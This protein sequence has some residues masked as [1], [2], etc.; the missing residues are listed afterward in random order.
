MKKILFPGVFLALLLATSCSKDEFTEEDATNAQKEIISYQDSIDH[1]R[2]SLNHIG[3][4]IQ[5]SVSVIPVNGGTGFSGG[6]S[7]KS[8]NSVKSLSGA[9][10]SVSQHG[11]LLKDT[12]DETGI[13]V[14]NDL[15]VGTVNVNVIAA[16]YT[17][18]NFIAEIAPEDDPNVNTYYEVLRHAATMVPVFSLTEGTSN[19]SG[20]LSY[21]TDLTNTA[22]EIASDVTVIAMIDVD[23]STFQENYFNDLWDDDFGKYHAKIVQIAYTDITG[24][25]VSDA[26]GAYSIE[27][28]SAADGLPFKLEISDIAV[29]QQLLMST[30]NDQP[31][32]GVQVVR[33]IFSSDLTY[34]TASDIDNVPAAYVVFGEPT[35]TITQQPIENAY[36]YAVIGES[37]IASIIITD[38]G[39]GY[40][41]PPIITITGDGEGAEA[42]AFITEGKVT[43]V[44]IT[45]AGKGYTY[46]NVSADDK[47]GLD[48]DA[49]PVITYGITSIN[50]SDNGSGYQSR[51]DISIVS[52]EGSGAS[53][54]AIM[55]GYVSDITVTSAGNNYVCP[56]TVVLT[57][58]IGT[59]A[60]ATANMTYYNPIHSIVLS[61]NFIENNFYESTPEVLIETYNTGSGATAFAQLS[62]AGTIDRIELADAGLGYTQA[63]S[64][65]VVGGGGTGATAYATLNGDGSIN[66]IVVE[67]GKGYTSDPTVQISAPPAGGTQAIGTPVRAFPIDNLVLTNVGSGY[68]IIYNDGNI[69]DYTN[70][71][72]IYIDG[73]NIG[74]DADVTVKPNMKVESVTVNTTG[75]EYTAAPSVS[76][77]P[78]CGYGSGAAATAEI[79]Y[80]VKQIDVVTQG[81][82]YTY[83]ATITVTVVTP[84][85]GCTTQA[86]ATA[87]KGDGVLSSIILDEGGE[88]YLAP[89]HVFLDYSTSSPTQ[90]AEIEAI[91]SNGKIT[92]FTITNPGEGYP[93]TSPSNFWIDI[94]TH[95]SGA[96]FNSEAYPQSGK[97]SFV[98]ISDPGAGY[99]VVP[100]IRFIRINQWG[101]PVPSGTFADAEA[102][103]VVQ[104]GR[105]T[106][107]NITNPGTGY[108]YEPIVEIVVPD[109]LEVAKGTVD[110]NDDGYITGVNIT[111]SG[112]G[113]AEVPAVSFFASVS[114]MGTGATGTAIIEDGQV[115]DVVM[116]SNGSGY[117]GKNTPGTKKGVTF[118]PSGAPLSTFFVYA[119]KSYIKDIHLGTGKRTIEH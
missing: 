93:Y 87:T 65:L 102:T 55:S 12:T 29:D 60:T 104:D 75:T 48:A 17:G 117:L 76:F 106:A 79:L 50:M 116:T 54:L 83:D 113:Y 36:A 85:E 8:G 32:N 52:N 86:K 69:D 21:E 2:D 7:L 88:N 82:G 30:L 4:I 73:N 5:Y 110:I 112:M 58:S 97:I 78:K 91:V 53:G 92:G 99:T 47:T 13:A 115:V 67:G 77:V 66:I 95:T 61:D 9:V 71:P 101:Y 14:F 51:P 23:N 6:S 63:P 28:P 118:T 64:V 49:T 70:E 33:T 103:A 39:S 35:G 16:D 22:P 45:E 40:T 27:I 1:V 89:P 100:Q 26:T 15:R 84:P 46:A 24:S 59:N 72:Y 108:Y 56:P 25:A 98:T 41:Q 119:G 68:D 111:N 94:T 44:Q 11:L 19:I 62:S 114:G 20:K 10:V 74:T 38:Q 81:S 109:Y 18:A 37:G 43:S 105:V 3:G 34:S 107:I 31:V 57:G 90:E 80:T 42:V 96:S